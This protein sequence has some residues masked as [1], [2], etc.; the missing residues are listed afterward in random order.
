MLYTRRE[1]IMT[2]LRAFRDNNKA[3]RCNETGG[4]DGPKQHYRID[5][6]L[7][8]LRATYDLPSKVASTAD[9]SF[10]RTEP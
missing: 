2:V 6:A 9:T 7:A 4:E 8:A 3:L 1:H 10:F 5:I